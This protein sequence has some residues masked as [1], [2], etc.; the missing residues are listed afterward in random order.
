[1]RQALVHDDENS[2]NSILEYSNFL[3]LDEAH[4]S[5]TNIEL[6]ISR[7]VPRLKTVKNLRL[8]LMSAT[9]DVERFQRRFRNMGIQEDQMCVF[10]STDRF[11]DLKNYCLNYLTPKIRDN[12]EYAFRTVITLHHKYREGYGTD[13][14]GRPDASLTGPIVVFVPGKAEIKIMIDTI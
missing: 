13:E 11:Q 5:S 3:M 8:V 7:E 9:I 1:M 14:Q 12:L 4:A 6:I 2:P 10:G